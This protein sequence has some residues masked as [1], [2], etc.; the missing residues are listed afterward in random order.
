[1]YSS[2]SSLLLFFPAFKSGRDHLVERKAETPW[3]REWALEGGTRPPPSNSQQD[4]QEDATQRPY[5]HKNKKKKDKEKRAATIRGGGTAR[6]RRWKGWI[7]PPLSI[8][9]YRRRTYNWTKG[10]NQ[11]GWADSAFHFSPFFFSCDAHCIRL[12]LSSLR[13]G[14]Q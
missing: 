8:L 14:V 7:P 9:P 2:S 6:G 3:G 4:Q 1:M 5:I 11:W 10:R 12:R 13:R